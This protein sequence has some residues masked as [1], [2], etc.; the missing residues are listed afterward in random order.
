MNPEQNATVKSFYDSKKDQTKIFN[1]LNGNL[2]EDKL[3][4]NHN[5][6][7]ENN[8]EDEGKKKSEYKQLRKRG[9]KTFD[10]RSLTTN[11]SN[12]N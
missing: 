5:D 1:K 9:Q 10:L 3:Q 8:T 7:F 12:S 4:T 11:Y 6:S 2:Y